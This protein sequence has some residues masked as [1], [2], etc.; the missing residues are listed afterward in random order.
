MRRRRGHWPDAEEKD[1][2]D[3]SGTTISENIREASANFFFLGL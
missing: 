3:S 1:S 2:R